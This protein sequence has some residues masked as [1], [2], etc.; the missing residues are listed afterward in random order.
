MSEILIAHDHG[1]LRLDTDVIRSVA[2]R[3]VAGENG[4]LV[5]L[6][7]VLAD[8]DSVADLNKR[9]LGREYNTDVLAFS[10]SDEDESAR[11]VDG[12][13]YIDLDTAAERAPEFGVT[14]IEEAHRYII[15]GILHLLGYDDATPEEKAEMGALEDRYLSI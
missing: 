15:H 5:S 3:V 9:Y 11:I 4:A 13:I 2:R 14:Y 10:L 6:S 8:H 1:G 7:I 12:E